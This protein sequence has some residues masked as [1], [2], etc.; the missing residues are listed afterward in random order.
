MWPVILEIWTWIVAQAESLWL[1]VPITTLLIM[2]GRFASTYWMERL[3]EGRARK[4]DQKKAASEFVYVADSFRRHWAQ[5]YY[6]SQNAEPDQTGGSM[7]PWAVDSFDPLLTPERQALYSRLSDTLRTDAYALD[8]QVK[9]A[10]EELAALS[11]YDDS[12]V[13]LDAPI[14][15]C[16]IAI[17]ADAL[18]VS[19]LREA[20]LKRPTGYDVLVS[21]KEQ[22]QAFRDVKTKA[23]EAQKRLHDDWVRRTS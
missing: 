18:W 1:V 23:E 20:G 6:D 21:I 15:S 4:A 12:A 2:V 17:A 22:L 16:E 3:R 5:H 11:R 13:D 10:K 8:H 7:I 9:E 14:Y 19:A